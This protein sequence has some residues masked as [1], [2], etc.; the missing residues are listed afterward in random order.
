MPI[1]SCRFKM[2][3][4][5]S[6]KRWRLQ[7]R[8]KLTLTSTRY[9]GNLKFECVSHTTSSSVL[10]H[11]RALFHDNKWIW[12]VLRRRYL[13]TT[14]EFFGGRIFVL[15]QITDFVREYNRCI[16]KLNLLFVHF[17]F[18]AGSPKFYGIL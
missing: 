3:V 2:P 7:F 18:Y 1:I 17:T 12:S 16:N 11:L 10:I 5:S 9:E 13:K 8:Y 6:V 4:H 14:E 15:Q